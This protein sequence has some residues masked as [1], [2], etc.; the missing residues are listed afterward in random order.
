M[1]KVRRF[2]KR[3]C[4]KIPFWIAIIAL[5]GFASHL[6]RPIP[7]RT[8]KAPVAAAEITT[9]YAA[10]AE[11]E[12]SVEEAIKY[13]CEK[14]DIP[15]D[16]ALAISKLETGHYTSTAYTE[17][18]NVGGLSIELGIP[19]RGSDNKVHWL[20]QV[21]DDFWLK[22]KEFH[23]CPTDR[24]EERKGIVYRW[25]Y[26]LKPSHLFDTKEMSRLIDGIVED[27]KA[28]G[29]ETLPPDKIEELKQKWGAA[30]G[31]IY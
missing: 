10:E 24:T 23:F 16:V 5:F 29:I 26:L 4:I 17:L 30:N 3:N 27:A 7:D 12:T 2:L 11:G 6:D 8:E 19:W 20:L 28:L 31:R 18:N 13:A 15:H 1:K 14:Y 9:A 25:F 22:Q 21:D